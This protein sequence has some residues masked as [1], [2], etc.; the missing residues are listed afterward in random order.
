MENIGDIIRRQRKSK[1]LTQEELGKIL[2]VSKQAVSKWETGR[3]LPDIEM[4]RKLCAVLDI[5]SDE[6]IG[7][8]VEEVKH[9][10]RWIKACIVCVVL[11]ILCAAFFGLGGLEYI[12]HHTQSGVAFLTVYRNGVLL[13]A[14]QYSVQSNSDCRDA[15]NGYK[16]STDY[17]E[18]RGIVRFDNQCEVEYGFIN[19]NDWHNIQIR[20]E[21]AESGE[22]LSAKQFISYETDGNIFEVVIT[23]D[24]A[25][26]GQKISVFR[27]GIN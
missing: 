18:I 13:S 14:D 5:K 7:S 25:A 1:N 6:I 24:T 15:K 11:S 4:L 27:E 26:A 10:R 12:D 19:T 8:S 17:G 23:E 20:L 3:S 16:I 21:I 22:D 2:F 9:C